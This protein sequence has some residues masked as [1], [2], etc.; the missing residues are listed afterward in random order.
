MRLAGWNRLPARI[1]L[2]HIRIIASR[3]PTVVPGLR[4]V[5]LVVAIIAIVWVVIPSIGI[6]IETES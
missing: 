4:G 5:G 6:F 3:I 2:R 1:A